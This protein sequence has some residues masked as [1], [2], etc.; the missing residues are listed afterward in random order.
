M[1]YTKQAEDEAIRDRIRKDE[2]GCWRWTGATSPDGYGKWRDR[3]TRK[4]LSAHRLMYEMEVGPIPPGMVVMHTCDCPPCVNPAHLRVG[5]QQDNLRDMASK[6]RH[7]HHKDECTK[8]HP[9]T[10]DNTYLRKRAT[11]GRICRTCMRE[12]QR[13][14]KR[15]QRAKA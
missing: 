1:A 14:W 6:G 8:G 4:I 7:R 15:Q 2:D 5:T 9:F 3:G 11:G 12:Y 13:E 10:P